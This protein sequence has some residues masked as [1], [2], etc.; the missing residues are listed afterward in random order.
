MNLAYAV[1]V[2]LL[3][4]AYMALFGPL[5]GV[6]TSEDEMN[7]A[8]THH[9]H[10]THTFLGHNDV[11]HTFHQ[12]VLDASFEIPPIAPQRNTIIYVATMGA[13]LRANPHTGV[14]NV[15]RNIPYG[16][17]LVALQTEDRWVRVFHMGTEGYV[18]LDDVVDKA[19]YVYPKFV[20][21]ESNT[22]IDPNTERVRAMIED[23]FSCGESDLPLQ[24]E[25]YVLY[26]IVRT[27]AHVDW[28]DV[29]PRVA[30]TWSDILKDRPQTTVSTEPKI[31]SVMEFRL[32]NGQGHLAFVESVFDDGSVQL[33]EAN[34]PENGIYNE[35]VIVS[36][37][38][39]KLNPTFITFA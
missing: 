10:T 26:K 16:S 23:T 2:D 24:A 38:W 22:S 11:S 5:E 6:S 36:E 21:G 7:Q 9:S 8:E 14:D 12:K 27:G 4:F 20:I 13:P 18:S 31:R 37:E 28:G 3:E 39:K 29:R 1:A 30:G 34:W 19:A 17:M 35:R 25:E 15:I 33:S 32:E